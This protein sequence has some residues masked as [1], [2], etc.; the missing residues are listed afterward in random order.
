MPHRVEITLLVSLFALWVL[1][2]CFESHDYVLP[3]APNPGDPCA[4]VAECVGGTRCV[5]PGLFPGGYCSNECEEGCVGDTRCDFAYG[6]GLCLLECEDD[7]ECR[8][9]YH[10]FGD[11]CRPPCR[12]PEDCGS[13]EALCTDGRCMGPECASARDCA[14]GSACFEGRCIVSPRDAGMDLPVGAPC[15]SASE[16]V[17]GLCLPPELGGTCGE[18]CSSRRTCRF[19]QACA[20]TLIDRDGDGRLEAVTGACVD[21]DPTGRFLAG[22]CATGSDCESRS[23]IDGQCVEVCETAELDCLPGQA[24][25]FLSFPGPGL[26]F[27]GCGYAPRTGLVEVQDFPLGTLSLSASGLSTRVNFAIPDD[28][29]SVTLFAQNVGGEAVPIAYRSLD[30]PDDTRLFDLEELA[31]F[32]DQPIRWLPLSNEE[33]ATISVPSSTPDRVDILPGRYGAQVMLLGDGSGGARS[34]D[35]ELTMRVKRGEA[36]RGGTIDLDIYLVGVGFDA[37]A[38]PGEARLTEATE[39]LRSIWATAGLTLGDI[40]FHDVAAAAAGRLSIIDTLDGRES[41]LAELMRL[42]AGTTG[43]AISIF[44]VR[45]I[46]ADGDGGIILGIAGGIPGPPGVHGTMHSGVAVTYDSS[47]I[48]SGTRGARNLAQIIAHETGH[49][50]GLYHVRER[51]PPCP[52]GTGPTDGRPCAPFGG[53][54]VL[55]DTSPRDG[56]NLMWWALGG[57]TGRRYNVTLSPG[58]SSVLLRSPVVLP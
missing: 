39:N 22:A 12:N 57:D 8:L 55:A 35:V 54:D 25:V 2:A 18:I 4:T 1:P 9:G 29:V 23:C 51:L 31:S 42:G 48:G 34:A 14:E 20:P 53:G 17:T 40:R 44:L 3:V 43:D 58:Q 10:C 33:A 38:A 45:S 28:A 46:A 13:P 26:Q 50:L 37:S 21:G 30:A 52:A 41:E 27:P 15:F 19:D 36:L 16:C 11:V 7:S 47:V 5:F 56:E 32:I 49:Y 24:C 6:D